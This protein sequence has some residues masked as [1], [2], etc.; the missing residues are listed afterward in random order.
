MYIHLC[1]KW[2]V[3]EPPVSKISI[4]NWCPHRGRQLFYSSM[5]IFIG[6]R[7]KIG[8]WHPIINKF[9]ACTP[10]NSI[11]P[12]HKSVFHDIFQNSFF[13]WQISKFP[14][15]SLTLKKTTFPWLFPDVW[16]PCNNYTRQKTYTKAQITKWKVSPIYIAM[17]YG[18]Y[19][20]V[21][22]IFACYYCTTDTMNWWN[23]TLP[24]SRLT[25]VWLSALKICF[26][27]L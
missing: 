26:N 12:W 11:F 27:I 18:I 24:H 14:D 25:D 19:S 8:T 3:F 20:E 23:M 16:Q 2:D 15:I 13:P 4:V 9:F 22:G 17:L 21:Y 1:F 7:D 10:G 5:Y 6:A